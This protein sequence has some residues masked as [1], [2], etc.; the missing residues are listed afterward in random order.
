LNYDSACPVRAQVV[1]DPREGDKVNVNDLLPI[2]VMI[3]AVLDDD[4]DNPY[5]TGLVTDLVMEKFGPA[6]IAHWTFYEPN[7]YKQS[8][9]VRRELMAMKE[10]GYVGEVRVD[11]A[12]WFRTEAGTQRLIKE[13]VS[14]V[15]HKV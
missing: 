10:S 13:G 2:D 6:F 11:R 14:Y 1:D 8:F 3:L 12:Y 5:T 9:R 15:G 7:K 4:E